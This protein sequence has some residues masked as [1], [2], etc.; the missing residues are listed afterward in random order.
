M[1][2][3][4]V[5]ALL[6]GVIHEAIR[7]WGQPAV[8]V[9]CSGNFTIERTLWDVG[10][11]CHSCDVSLYSCALGALF[12]G[13]EQPIRV[14]AEHAAEWGWLEPYLSTG[15]RERCAVLMLSTTMLTGLGRD[16][17]YYKRQRQAYREQWDRLFSQ[18]VERLGKVPIQLAS[19]AA[20]DVMSWLERVPADAGIVSF[21]PFWAAGYERLYKPLDAVFEWDERPDYQVLDEERVERFLGAVTQREQWLLLLP[22]ERKDLASRLRGKV[23]QTERGKAVFVYASHAPVRRIGP[24]QTITHTR[25]PILSGASVGEK[26]SIVSLSA[27]EFNELRAMY[28]NPGIAPGSVLQ[29][30]GLLMDGVLVGAWAIARADATRAIAVGDLSPYVY[31]MS[32]FP[33]G[34][35]SVPRLSSLVL[36]A[37]LSRESQLLAERSLHS[38]VRGLVTTAFSKRPVSMKY[39]GLFRLLSRKEE[40]GSFVLNYGAR[41]GQWG[42]EE[43]VKTWKASQ[44]A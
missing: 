6:R 16:N 43:G 32:D 4:S 29:A 22:E 26:A 39:R 10:V 18:T 7:G 35:G 15:Q 37:A 42:L 41:L 8:Y 2:Q 31:L 44:P 38:R 34:D 28:L 5:P 23:Q 27:G 25:L 3:G 24:H 14:K 40:A 20:E 12:S 30:Y 21:P 9:G 36:R 17:A 1:F 33:V 11:R 13:I 19:F